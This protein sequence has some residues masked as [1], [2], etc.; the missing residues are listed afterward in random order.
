MHPHVSTAN[1]LQLAHKETAKF[2]ASRNGG[3]D[4]LRLT[5]RI[6][7]GLLPTRQARARGGTSHS[8]GRELTVA[9]RE[10]GSCYSVLT[11]GRGTFRNGIMRL[12]NLT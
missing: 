9:A 6:L 8:G 7:P 10:P 5:P 12:S 4:S 2:Q 3:L 1:L 11:R